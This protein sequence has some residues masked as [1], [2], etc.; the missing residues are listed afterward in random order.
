M[1]GEQVVLLN[2]LYNYIQVMLKQNTEQSLSILNSDQNIIPFPHS[3][4]RNNILSRTVREG[5]ENT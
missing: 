5:I 1:I 3:A 4:G 2:H